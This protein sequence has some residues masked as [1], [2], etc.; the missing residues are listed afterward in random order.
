MFCLIN[1][2][3]FPDLHIM[4]KQILHSPTTQNDGCLDRTN[5][6]SN[7]C[8]M[9]NFFFADKGDK[10]YVTQKKPQVHAHAN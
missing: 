6:F 8:K 9:P 7:I 10:V 2:S 1:T 4:D 3:V 5:T